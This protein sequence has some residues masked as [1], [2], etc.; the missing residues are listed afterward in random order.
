VAGYIGETYGPKYFLLVALFL[1]NCACAATPWAAD[2]IGSYGVILCRVVQ[3]FSQGFLYPSI[4]VML[5][6]WAPD[7]ERATLNNIVFVGK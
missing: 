6:T 2:H 1:N 5:G 7:D 3:G 4:H